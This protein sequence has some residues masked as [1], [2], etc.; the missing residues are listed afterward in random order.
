MRLD[1]VPVAAVVVTADLAL[2]IG[3]LRMTGGSGRIGLVIQ[4]AA[5]LLLAPLIPI[6]YA[7]SFPDR[8]DGDPS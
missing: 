1:S 3:S 5:M 7:V 6:L 8:P 2:L 4:A